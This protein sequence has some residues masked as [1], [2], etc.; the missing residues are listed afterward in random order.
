MPATSTAPLPTTRS[1][2]ERAL[3]RR[4]ADLVAENTQFRVENTQLR[5]ENA[6]LMARLADMEKRFAELEARL[7]ENSANSDR[8]PSSDPPWNKPP[9]RPREPT[10]RKRGGQPGHKGVTRPLLPV[11]QV[12]RV[13]PLVPKTCRR[14]RAPLRQKRDA[15]DPEPTRHQITEVPPPK[16][17]TTEYQA[18]GT[19]C[20]RCGEVTRAEL[21]REVAGSAFGP[22]LQARVALLTGRYRLS[23]RET[24]E[25]IKDLFGV[26]LALGTIT[27][28]EQA[29]SDALKA[30]Y[31]EALK[32]VR[33]AGVV[34]ADETGWRNGLERAWLW[35]A[36]TA[37]LAV[38]WIDPRR[39]RAAF[40]RFLGKFTGCLVT[41]RWGAYLRHPKRLHQFCWAHLKRDFEKLVLRGGDAA[42][43]GNAALAEVTAIFALWHRFKNGEINRASLRRLMAPIQERF[44]LLL[45]DGTQNSHQKA[46]GL[47]ARL[48][49]LW[50]CLWVF[51]RLPD[52]EPTNNNGERDL[53]KA[54][55]WRKGSFGCQS[56]G[57]CTYVS[58]IL[59]AAACLRKQHRNVLEFLEQAVRA[60]RSGT[61]PP[62]LLPCV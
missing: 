44:F 30:P 21:P 55:L 54:V 23:R 16:L 40:V 11:E 43:L 8:P 39:N 32:T 24:V 38:F 62:S 10:G 4:V 52:V 31:E 18:H 42:V 13:V 57:G 17:V 1:S 3:E 46:S 19:A 12:D 34:N 26:D 20:D 47:C 50:S 45:L 35:I 41:D 58:R 15:R 9:T 48:I 28:I 37:T 33:D 59:T 51:V 49:P 25:A 53:R 29:T 56:D 2:R 27:A 14:C 61:L 36:V 60:H 5:V 7:K 6:A 22:G